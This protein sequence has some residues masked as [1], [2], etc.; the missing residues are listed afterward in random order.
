MRGWAR[1]F[2]LAAAAV[3]LFGLAG[4]YVESRAAGDQPSISSSN[5]AANNTKPA[6]EVTRATLKNGLRVVIV[7]D[8]LAPVATTV[9]NYLVGSNETPPGFPGTAHAQE[10]MMFRGAPGFRPA[11]WRTSL[12]RWAAIQRRY[13]TD[14][15]AILL[16]RSS[17]RCG[18]GAAHR[19]F[20]DRARS[21]PTNCGIRSAARS[22]RKW[23]RTSRI[24][25]TSSTPNC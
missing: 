18:C 11:S 10:H 7:A 17:R 20:A 23:R 9:V 19:G 15:D 4:N 16:H 2:F 8:K 24:P 1:C 3:V 6:E 13:A 5:Q 25:S 22:S 21:I 12:R 14:G